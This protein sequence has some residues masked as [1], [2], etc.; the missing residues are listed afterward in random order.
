M[1]NIRVV[2]AEDHALVRAGISALLGSLRGVEVVGQVADGA[3]AIQA[4]EE[5]QPD[6]A[7][8][9]ITMQGMSGLDATAII[10]QKFPDVRV[11]ILSMHASEEY[12]LQALR[13]GAAGYLLKDAGIDELEIAL[14]SVAAGETYLSPSVSRHIAAYVKRTGSENEPRETLT[15]R[16]REILQRIARG[17][18]TQQIAAELFIS[19]KTVETH[20]TQLQARLDIHDVAGLVRYA[21]RVG[22]VDSD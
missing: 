8:L 9:D 20:R 14:R 12:V 1:G 7:I 18:T 13:V 2:L 22:L 5:L 3:T 16:Q 21:I 4:I 6:L 15:P 19:A 11:M 10:T 17:R